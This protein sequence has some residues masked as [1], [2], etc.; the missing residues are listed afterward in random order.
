MFA[1]VSGRTRVVLIGV[2]IIVV[3]EVLSG[4]TATVGVVVGVNF[5]CPTRVA[6]LAVILVVEYAIAVII[7]P[8]GLVNEVN[9]DCL[10]GCSLSLGG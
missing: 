1:H 3:V 9:E 5:G 10:A 2:V 8:I 4:V 7:V 6:E